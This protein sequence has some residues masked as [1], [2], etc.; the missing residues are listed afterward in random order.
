RDGNRAERS[1]A[2]RQAG[3]IP[4]LKRAER[5]GDYLLAMGIENR[6]L[7]S[8]EGGQVW[9]VE[10]EH[11]ERARQELAEFKADPESARYD[12]RREAESIRKRERREQEL[13]KQRH[14]DVRTTWARRSRAS[15]A[16]VTM[17][18][19]LLCVVLFLLLRYGPQE[20]QF[21]F[22]YLTFS[23]APGLALRH[24]A[25]GEVWRLVTPIFLH[26]NLLHLGFNMLWLY[27]LGSQV[28]LQRGKW[29]FTALLL[30]F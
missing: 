13:A 16:P 28:E 20:L 9:I 8:E 18:L 22:N 25:E 19:I 14:I 3:V 6:V 27:S 30:S 11:L 12:R 10:T 15:S 21:Y 4:D 17:G 26:A 23:L 2:V 7:E 24:L 1:F 5:F 29:R